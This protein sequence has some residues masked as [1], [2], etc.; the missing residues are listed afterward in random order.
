M[1]V[2]DVMMNFCYGN[3]VQNGQNECMHQLR[4][5]IVKHQQHNV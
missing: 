4:V 2:F 3:P 5:D 1:K